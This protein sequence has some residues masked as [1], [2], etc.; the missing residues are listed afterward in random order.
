ML[1]FSTRT[2]TE[3]MYWKTTNNV[4]RNLLMVAVKRRIWNEWNPPQENLNLNYDDEL[5]KL[6]S[7]SFKSLVAAV[8]SSVQIQVRDMSTDSTPFSD[9]P[10][11]EQPYAPTF[12]STSTLRL[13]L[14][15]LGSGT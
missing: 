3:S 10:Y 7:L 9:Q 13:R 8:V 1:F 12:S 5:R 14:L 4:R 6:R 2:T 15:V 11:R